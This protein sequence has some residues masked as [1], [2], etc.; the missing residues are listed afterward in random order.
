MKNSP[1]N[2]AIFGPG[3]LGGSI[4]YAAQQAGL[5]VKFWGRSQ[6]KLELVKSQGFD[7]SGEVSEVID[8]ADIIILA[9]PVP[10]MEALVK[11]LITA[12]LRKDQI[13]TDVGSVKASVLESIQPLL[14]Q[15]GYTFI[16]AHPMAGAETQ[17]FESAYAELLQGATCILT[18]DQYSDRNALDSLRC[19]WSAVGMNCMTLPADEHDAMISRVSH[20][21][22][23]LASVC[24]H[25]ALPDA[26][27]GAYAGGGLRD[28]SR[29]ASGAAHLWRGILSENRAEI[30]EHLDEAISR[31]GQ[32]KAAL[33]GAD[34]D[35][36]ESLLA[37]DKGAR[38]SYYNA[39]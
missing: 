31:L 25:V 37:E 1:Q 38:D 32:Y 12:G 20:V 4:G 5:K 15:E 29:V 30:V 26:G 9:V 17:G 28:T 27:N 34:D 7:A 14:G 35:L 2:I 33:Q 13:V 21:P 8:E 6:S 23:I 39:P 18:P 36:L 24:A 3:L 11:Q 19:F 16:G 10:N 22:H